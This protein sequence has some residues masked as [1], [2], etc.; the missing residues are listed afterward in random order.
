MS[1]ELKDYL[2]SINHTKENLLDSDDEMWEKKYTP[3]IVNKAVYPFPDTVLLVNEMNQCHYLDNRLQFDFL[4]NSIRPRKRYAPWLKASKIDNLELVKEYFGYSD[5][6][7][8]DAL[9]ILSDDD[10]EYIQ[11][12]LNKGG[13]GK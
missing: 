10:L 1:Y 9:K 3:F 4:L 5:Q 13:Y 7:A 8:K 11:D 6:K 2:N 12:K